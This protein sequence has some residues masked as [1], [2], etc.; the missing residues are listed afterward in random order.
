MNEGV[1]IVTTTSNG[2][3]TIKKEELLQ[4]YLPNIYTFDDGS[5]IIRTGDRI[6]KEKVERLYWASKEVA[7]QYFR[8]INRDKPLEEGNPDDILTIVIYNDPEEYK[9]NEEIYGYSTNNGGLYIEGI[10]TLF[11]YDRTPDQS[12]F[13]LE[14]LFRHEF[15]H[16]LQG[17]YAVPGMWGQLEIYK[18]DRLTWFEEGAAE[19]FAGSTRTSIL[20]RKSIIGNIISAEAASRYDF[21]QTL[22]SKYS[23]GFDFYNYACVAID[24]ILNE[25][26]DIYYNL[27]QY[28]KNN[29]VE[30]YDAYMEKIK[31]D[32]NL[33]DE[34][35]AYMDQRINQ[36]ESLS[37]PSVSDDY[38]ASH[39]EKKESEILDEIVGVSNI[40]DPV[41]ET[42]KSE[43]FNTFTLRGSYVGGISQ[44]IIKDIE[45]MNNIVHDI[46]EKLD[47]YSWTGYKT[48]TAYFVNHRVDENNNMVFDMVFHGILP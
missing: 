44:G 19:F 29:H 39:P 33:K 24:F 22:E 30:G 10:G 32:P 41:M 36:Y 43:F 5:L 11:T 46:L 8:Y 40:K 27:S 1:D 4:K 9:M 28:I 13:S 23:S 42:R 25:H 48:V 35:K 17:R 2:K 15:T 34:F 20:P 45:A 21:K 47:N 37:A 26:F 38:L 16:Y 18:D 12:R 6:S 31:K 7:A 14:E 3:D